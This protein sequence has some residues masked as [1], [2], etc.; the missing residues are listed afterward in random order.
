MLVRE[1]LNDSTCQRGAWYLPLVQQWFVGCVRQCA[2]EGCWG[3]GVQG[4][5]G[6]GVGEGRGSNRVNNQLPLLKV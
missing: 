4:L 5:R 1:I 6:R 3:R 2:V